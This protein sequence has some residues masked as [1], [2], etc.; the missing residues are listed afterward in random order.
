LGILSTHI[1]LLARMKG[2]FPFHGRVL[3]IGDQTVYADSKTCLRILQESNVQVGIDRFCSEEPSGTGWGF[4]TAKALLQ[5]LGAAEVSS[6]DVSAYEGAGIIH[7]LNLPIPSELVGAFDV[8]LDF[9][10]L[11]HIFD[12]RQVLANYVSLVKVGGHVVLHYPSSGAIDH[13]FYSI[14]PTLLYDFFTANGF[15]DMQ[16]FLMVAT[17][18]YSLFAKQKVYRYNGVGMQL[19]LIPNRPAGLLFFARKDRHVEA[20]AVPSQTMYGQIWR[21]PSRNSRQEVQRRSWLR[22]LLS[23]LNRW[24]RG[25]RP[26]LID[27]F[28]TTVLFDTGRERG[29]NVHY[30]GRY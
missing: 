1:R 11:E 9:G 12:V 19:P 28:V 4:V 13:G 2:S 5:A 6:M 29:S 22:R 17:N 23:M 30:L 14:S 26:E 18:K 20:L 21:R 15:D 10:S 7:D 25:R 27:S 8:L 24:T 3:T 16:C